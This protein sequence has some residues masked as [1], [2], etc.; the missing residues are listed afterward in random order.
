LSLDQGLLFD[1]HIEIR[2]V[3]ERSFYNEIIIKKVYSQRV[4][5]W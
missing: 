1:S 3:I 4:R 5:S 2:A